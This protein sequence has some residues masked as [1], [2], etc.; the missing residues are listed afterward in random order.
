VTPRTDSATATAAGALGI[1][2]AAAGFEIDVTACPLADARSRCRA[3]DAAGALADD[4][5]AA[6][7]D[8]GPA[9][10]DATP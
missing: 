6:P 1:W 9:S 3:L 7:A 10:A 8:E 5:D 4:E 2:L